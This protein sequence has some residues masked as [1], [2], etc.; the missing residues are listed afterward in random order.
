MEWIMRFRDKGG[1]YDQDIVAAPALRHH[2]STVPQKNLQA[3]VSPISQDQDT[4]NNPNRM[5]R[6]VYK[7]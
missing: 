6:Y 2:E 4:L 5:Q 1:F 3:P 7:V